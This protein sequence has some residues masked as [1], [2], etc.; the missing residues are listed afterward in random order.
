MIVKRQA[1]NEDEEGCFS[2]PGVYTKVRRQEDPGQG[3]TWRAGDRPGGRRPAQPSDPARADHLDGKLFIDY[4]GPIAKAKIG[5]KLRDF[6]AK[7]RQAQNSGAYPGD[8]TLI[9]RLD[10]LTI[11]SLAL[12]QLEEVPIIRRR[13]PCPRVNPRWGDRGRPPGRN[14]PH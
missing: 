3:S 10:G 2:F 8:D 7:F 5:A 11:P 4:A 6:E 13:R 12:A 9:R 1:S 14:L